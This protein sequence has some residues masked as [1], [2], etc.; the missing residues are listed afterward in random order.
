MSYNHPS[1][2]W[3]IAVLT[4]GA[5]SFF[6]AM[7][8]L[9]DPLS[10]SVIPQDQNTIGHACYPGSH[11]WNYCCL[12]FLS[13]SQVTVTYLTIGNSW[14]SSTY[15]WSSNEFCSPSS[16]CQTT[17]SIVHLLK[18]YF[19][20]KLSSVLRIRTICHAQDLWKLAR[21]CRP[22]VAFTMP[23]RPMKFTRYCLTQWISKLSGC[24]E[25]HWVRQLVKCSFIWN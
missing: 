8:I 18:Q 12:G 24:F 11:Y 7:V 3:F 2:D 19:T 17:C 5:I 20:C 21:S 6:D 1:L 4:K 25:I 16:G 14:I 15:T 22:A 23:A 10:S 9:T 13:L